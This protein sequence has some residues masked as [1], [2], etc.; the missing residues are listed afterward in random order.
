MGCQF[1]V[2]THT[3]PRFDSTAQYH[4][5]TK[6]GFWYFDD[7][8]EALKFA[9]AAASGEYLGCVAPIIRAKVSRESVAV[10]LHVATFEVQS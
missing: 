8:D 10:D 5:D 6:A 3:E 7:R 2:V 1:Y 4:G 9:K